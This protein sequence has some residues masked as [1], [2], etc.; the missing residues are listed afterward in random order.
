MTLRVALAD[1]Q[2]IIRDGLTYILQRL[3]DVELVGT[4][5][6][7]TEACDLARREHPDVFLMDLRMPEMDGL[8]ATRIIREELPGTQ[9]LVLTTFGDDESVFGALRHGA[10]GY[11]MKD[12]TAE[13]IAE[14]IARVAAGQAYLDPA[15]QARLLDSLGRVEP[16][17]VPIGP[18]SEALTAREAQ[19]V[20]LIAE[21]LS[22]QEI[23]ARLVLSEA[24]VK[25]HINNAFAK[26]GVRDR[27]QA[28]TWA[29]RTG[30][31]RP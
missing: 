8:E 20:A 26:L 15:V 11:L 10:R 13:A 3:P 17:A 18:G 12:A 6:D 1:D 29:Y 5:R 7:G 23:A 2:A 24:T 31:A 28:V 27:A 21:G 14:A 22:N 30:L 19:I 9:V 25:T 4:A 16:G